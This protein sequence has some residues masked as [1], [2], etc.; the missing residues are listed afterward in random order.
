M[1]FE[2]FIVTTT[3]NPP[4]EAILR[5]LDFRD[6][7]LIIVGDLKTPHNLY[8]KLQKKYNN[9]KYIS[10]EEQD[11][12]YNNLSKIL[13]W[14][15]I[16]RR[17]IGFIEAYKMGAKIIATVDDD[18]IPYKFWGKELYVNKEISVHFYKSKL[19]VCDPL[20]VTNHS[21]LWHRGY[22]IQLLKNKNKLNYIGKKR[23]KVLVQADLWNGNPDIDAIARISFNDP[24]IIFKN[25]KYPFAF[26]KIS[27]FNSQNTFLSREVIPYYC[28]FP[29]IG[30]MDDIWGSYILQKYFPGCVIYNRSSV[31][32]KRNPHNIVKDLENEFYGYKNTF[33]LIKNLKNFEEFLP[34]YALKFW[35]KYRSYFK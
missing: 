33:N 14:N 28:C 4:T 2:K 15:N 22:P 26:N 32:Q 35:V 21:Y 17:N 29:F 16:Q 9:L 10:P 7:F 12:K 19:L 27:P 6:W 13:G 23:I 1:I 34:K 18:N 30:R 25:F 8:E 31:Y 5:Y 3:I 11:K 20:S 24:Y